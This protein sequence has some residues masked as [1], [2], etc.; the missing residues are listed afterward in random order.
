MS[1]ITGADLEAFGMIKNEDSPAYPYEKHLTKPCED[2]G[3]SV[4]LVVTVERNAQEF[5]LKLPD[6]CTLFLKPLNLEEL[7]TFEQVIASWG[8]S[9]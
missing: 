4:S 6:G 7:K 2:T 8:P 3:K 1:K 9:W 5:A